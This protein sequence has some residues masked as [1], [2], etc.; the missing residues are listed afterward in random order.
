M[1]KACFEALGCTVTAV[2][3]GALA[4]AQLER[5]SFEL[6]VVDYDLGDMCATDL[7]GMYAT[8]TPIVIVTGSSFDDIAGPCQELG[9]RA[10]RR[11]PLHVDA[12]RE[13][14]ALVGR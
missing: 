10:V 11:K 14:L 1:H 13:I 12:A 6:A 5:G 2:R 4:G 9:A 3:T 7:L 8:T